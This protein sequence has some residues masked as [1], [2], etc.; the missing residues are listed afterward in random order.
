MITNEELKLLS[1]YFS[2][3]EVPEEME[4][5]V[6]KLNLIEQIEIANDKLQELMKPNK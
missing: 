4:I 3:K 6:K 2:D 5:L 1:K